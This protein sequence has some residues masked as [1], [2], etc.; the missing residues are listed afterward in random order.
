MLY[1]RKFYPDSMKNLSKWERNKAIDIANDLI[2][3]KKM[4]RQKAIPISIIKA[5]EWAE[6]L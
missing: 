3:K 6:H 1:T 4:D 2:D 5:Q